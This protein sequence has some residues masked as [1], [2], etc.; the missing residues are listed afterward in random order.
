MSGE[1]NLFVVTPWIAP[2]DG[3]QSARES[4]SE[5]YDVQGIS[6][7]WP[8]D[9]SVKWHCACPVLDFDKLAC[10]RDLFL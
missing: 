1:E 5:L 7:F 6:K 4:S 3:G 10:A 2:P 9:K 8:L